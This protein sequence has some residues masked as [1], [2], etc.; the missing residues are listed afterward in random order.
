MVLINGVLEKNLKMVS[1]M[2]EKN[3]ND[4]GCGKSQ[5]PNDRT[6]TKIKKI[7]KKRL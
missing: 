3:N 4:C 2:R 1:K 5:K 7:V 6:K